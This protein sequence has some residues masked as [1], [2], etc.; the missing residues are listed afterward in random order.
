MMATADRV[1]WCP[2]ALKPMAS[3][4]GLILRV[5]PRGGRLSVDQARGIADVARRL[6]NGALDLTQRANLQIRGLSEDRLAPALDRLNALGLL[7][8]TPEAEAVRNVVS[9]PLEGVTSEAVSSTAQRGRGTTRS[10]VEGAPQGASSADDAGSS[11][12]EMEPCRFTPLP[13]RRAWSPSPISMG[14]DERASAVFDISPHVAMLESHLVGTPALHALPAKFSFVVDNG[15]R[16]GLRDVPADIRFEAFRSRSGPAFAVRLGGDE[17]LAGICAPG[18]LADAAEALLRVFLDTADAGMH[19]M[20]DLVAR[21]GAEAILH[22]A[23]V[24]LCE[25]PRPPAAGPRDAIGPLGVAFGIGAPFGRLDVLQFETIVA[26][27]GAELRLTPWRSIL[28]PG[29]LRPDEAAIAYAAVGLI[30]DPA[31]PRLAVAACVGAPD[32]HRATTP[33][34]DHAASLARRLGVAA[35]GNGIV[36]HVSGC[37]KGCAHA[38]RAPLTFVGNE[39]RYDLVL[40]GR[41]DDPTTRRSLDI[42]EA[43]RCATLE[44]HA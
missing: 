30:T 39:G 5:K 2:G 14:E 16:L 9:S 32:C 37:R 36:L 17:D 4:D 12:G 35:A 7:D 23:G 13:P 41:P 6:G 1:G 3:G 40:D 8:P 21:I 25:A 22:R 19:R 28:L 26:A 29:L 38:G 33:V 31:D 10:V 34:L 20:A 42:D 18:D 44:L 43:L 15:G 11:P 24:G 27:A